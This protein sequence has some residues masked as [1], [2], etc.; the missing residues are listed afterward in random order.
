LKQDDPSSK[1][2]VAVKQAPS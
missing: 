1:Y 2:K